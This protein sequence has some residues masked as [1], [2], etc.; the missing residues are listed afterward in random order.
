MSGQNRKKGLSLLHWPPSID[1]VYSAANW[2]LLGSLLV[3]VT[4]TFFIITSGNER[5][6]RLRLQLGAMNTVAANALAQA[7]TANSVAANTNERAAKLE[8]EAAEARLETESIKS[9]AAWRQ[10]PQE[11]ASKLVAALSK[12]PG[13]INLRWTAGDPEARFLAIQFGRAFNAA[14]WRVASGEWSVPHGIVFG[15]DVPDNPSPDTAVLRRAL[16]SADIVFDTV[17]FPEPGETIGVSV[18][19]GATVLM[20]GSKKPFILQ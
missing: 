13:N 12:T 2:A 14:H 20:I 6:R 10:I 5:D 3:G 8:K 11:K 4:A 1:F 15:V 16:R 9:Q 19:P 17:S 7:G 18:I